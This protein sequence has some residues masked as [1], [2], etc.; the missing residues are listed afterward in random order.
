MLPQKVTYGHYS[1]NVTPRPDFSQY[2]S[3]DMFASQ[4]EKNRSIQPL[5][6]DEPDTQEETNKDLI[7][8]IVK[9]ENESTATPSGNGE[10]DPSFP[11]PM[12]INDPILQLLKKSHTQL[13]PASLNKIRSYPGVLTYDG[14]PVKQS[15][16]LTKVIN[17]VEDE[18]MDQ[19]T[20]KS[21]VSL[22]N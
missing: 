11:I 5:V 14:V 3:V 2:S 17:L 20:L 8:N 10:I 15:T 7:D 9:Q 13:P 1:S 12:N 18:P 16:I 22:V 21:S 19:K 4:S 6:I